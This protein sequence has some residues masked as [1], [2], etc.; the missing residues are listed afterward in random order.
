VLTKKRIA[1][2][3]SIDELD[4]MGAKYLPTAKDQKLTARYQQKQLTQSKFIKPAN[5][6]A[7]APKAK[8]P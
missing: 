6:S 4:V 8:K 2:C 3:R 5:P 7:T 1:V